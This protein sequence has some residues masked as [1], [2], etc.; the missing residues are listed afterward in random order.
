MKLGFILATEKLGNEWLG[1]FLKNRS[2]EY[3][4]TSQSQLRE[5]RFGVTTEVRGGSTTG[6]WFWR[7][8]SDQRSWIG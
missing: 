3:F 7:C 8:S 4:R 6:S 1:I 2:I 5:V